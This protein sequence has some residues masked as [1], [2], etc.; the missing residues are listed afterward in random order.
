[1][2]DQQ[3]AKTYTDDWD[4]PQPARVGPGEAALALQLRAGNGEASSEGPAPESARPLTAPR[5]A[6]PATPASGVEGKDF[7]RPAVDIPMCKDLGRFPGL[8]ARSAIFGV[9]RGGEEMKLTKLACYGD[10][11]GAVF[12]GPRLNMRDKRVWEL[13]LKAAKSFGCAGRECALSAND[14]A[15]ALGSKSKPNA[16]RTKAI[17]ASLERLAGAQVDYRVPGLACGSARLLGSARESSSGWRVSIDE[18]LI[19]ALDRDKQF[20][21]DVE[22]R[23]GLSTDLAKWMHDFVSTHAAGF[24]RGF[25]VSELEEL[26]G[27]GAAPS[28]FSA[29]LEKALGALCERCPEL[30]KGFEFTRPKRA[31]EGWRVRIDRGPEKESF[32]CPAAEAEQAADR[33]RKAREAKEARGSKPKRRGGP[34]L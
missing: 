26:S 31:A 32:R 17:R 27:W 4:E 12:S 16:R 18:G 1:M 19:V 13:A 22:R 29:Q 11:Y 28:K 2:G 24:E 23:E 33:T 6:P 5:P 10:D 3:N 30:V 20:R 14:I 21:I 8:F 15:A 7:Q 25:K 9:A 34:S